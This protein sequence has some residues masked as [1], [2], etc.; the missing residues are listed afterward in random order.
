MLKQLIKGSPGFIEK[1]ARY[2]YSSIPDCIKYGTKYREQ[3][4]FLKDSQFWNQ[5]QHEQY[6][7]IQIRKLLEH[8]YNNVP[9]YTKRFNEIGIKPQDI[10]NFKDF[11]N[12]PYLTKDLV[13]NN[14]NDLID[15]N[16]DRR[17]LKYVTSGGTMGIPMGFYVEPKADKAREWAFIT[18]LWC[19]VGYSVNRI[20]KCVIL[21]GI[22]PKK[23]FYEYLGRDLILSSFQMSEKNLRYYIDL[24]DSFNPD[25]IQAYP[26]SIHLLSKYILKNNVNINFNKLKCILCSSENLYQNQRFDIEQAFGVRVYNFYGHSEH[27]CIAGECEQSKNLHIQSEYGYTEIINENEIDVSE[28]DEVGEIVATGFNNYVMPFIR[29]KTGDLVV[30]SKEKCKCGR[31]YKIIKEFKGRNQDYIVDKTGSL[32]SFICSDDALWN[33]KDKISAYQFVQN[34]PGKV[35]LNIESN[36]KITIED[37]KIINNDFSIF[38]HS[39]DLD[40]NM[41]DFIE[42]TKRGKFKFLVQNIEVD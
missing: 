15:K 32:I 42:R 24:I 36:E 41:V 30:I 14:I 28:K 21:R 7:I 39:I 1:P 6:Q 20:N 31:S 17:N 11:K 18:N 33:V 2:I 27:A 9:Y 23:G 4:S 8:A 3:Y 10:N 26:S 5:E 12:L 22:I 29:Y 25:F 16:Y 35:I 40:I 13:R 38:F 19:R 34:E 37:L